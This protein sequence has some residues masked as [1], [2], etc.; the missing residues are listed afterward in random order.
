MRRAEAAHRGRG[1][2][3]RPRGVGTRRPRG[4]GA[5][6]G[7]RGVTSWRREVGTAAAGNLA[8]DPGCLLP[9]PCVVLHPG[10]RSLPV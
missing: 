10:P 7:M 2:T 6:P 4:S 8:G 1:G 3:R 9:V 5:R